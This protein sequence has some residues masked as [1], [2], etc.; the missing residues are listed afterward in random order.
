[1]KVRSDWAIT[2][3]VTLRGYV[4]SVGGV[5]EKV[6]AARRRGINKV[7]LPADNEKDLVDIPKAALRDMEIKF[8]R[9]MQEVIDIMLLEPPEY[10]ERDLEALD[11]EDDEEDESDE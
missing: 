11:D 7:I 1:R 2:G 10:R 6:L 5:K 8:V 9:H 3:E 4:L